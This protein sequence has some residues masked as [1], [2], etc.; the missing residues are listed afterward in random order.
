MFKYVAG[1]FGKLVTFLT[2]LMVSLSTMVSSLIIMVSSLISSVISIITTLINAIVSIFL[3]LL[4]PQY[5]IALLLLFGISFGSLYALG[6]DKII[7]QLFSKAK[8][9]EKEKFTDIKTKQ[10]IDFKKMDD[11]EKIIRDERSSKKMGGV[12]DKSKS[13]QKVVA[14]VDNEMEEMLDVMH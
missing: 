10:M 12:L 4:S 11:K 2:G 7:M 8:K 14:S 6:Y 1:F 5:L 9:D 3:K 13:W